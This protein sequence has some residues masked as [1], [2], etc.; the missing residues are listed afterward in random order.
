MAKIVLNVTHVTDE[1]TNT[2]SDAQIDV[3]SVDVYQPHGYVKDAMM[4]ASKYHIIDLALLR[5]EDD[6]EV[7]SKHGIPHYCYQ[8]G[9]IQSCAPTVDWLRLNTSCSNHAIIAALQGLD[10][11]GVLDRIHIV[12][13]V[14]YCDSK[15]DR[16][17][18]SV[19]HKRLSD[20][21]GDLE[22]I[23]LD[24]ARSGGRNINVV[25]R[26][27]DDDEYFTEVFVMFPD[28]GRHR[29]TMIGSLSNELLRDVSGLLC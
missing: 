12:N 1:A 20:D 14:Q 5:V 3:C 16:L 4:K 23:S 9:S 7:S 28:T 2:W 22:V 19:T 13:A 27:P 25:F 17:Y 6:G 10:D 15:Y 29:F 11:E 26:R 24:A 21:K 18:M 8:Q